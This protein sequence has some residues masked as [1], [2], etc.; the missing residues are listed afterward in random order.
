M[1][2]L[3][4]KMPLTVKTYTVNYLSQEVLLVCVCVCVL[5]FKLSYTLMTELWIL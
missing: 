5:K 3:I 4:D 1:N 2:R